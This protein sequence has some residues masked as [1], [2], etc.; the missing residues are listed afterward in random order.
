MPS[1]QLFPNA[2]HP[3]ALQSTTPSTDTNGHVVVTY[4]ILALGAETNTPLDLIHTIARDLNS[5]VAP[6][7]LVSIIGSRS[8]LARLMQVAPRAIAEARDV[9]VAVY[10]TIGFATSRA[11]QETF[12]MN[13][14]APRS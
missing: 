9:P 8:D 14:G 2:Q 11:Y 3:H 12:E 4:E 7:D 1:D 10:E 6:V 13:R 5:R